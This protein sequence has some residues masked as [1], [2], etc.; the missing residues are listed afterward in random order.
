MDH[1]LW[2]IFKIFNYNCVLHLCFKIS[3][4]RF[5]LEFSNIKIWNRSSLVRDMDQ[6]SKNIY[7]R[8]PLG[9]FTVNS[10]FQGKLFIFEKMLKIKFVATSMVIFEKFY[11]DFRITSSR[12][13]LESIFLVRLFTFQICSNLKV[14]FSFQPSNTNFRFPV[15]F[16]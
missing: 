6:W 10:S 8:I 2:S 14:Q 9:Q 5:N 4:S 13:A 11:Y 12:F 1:R 3:W 16:F 7:F 15:F